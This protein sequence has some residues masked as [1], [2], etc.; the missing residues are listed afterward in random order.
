MILKGK[1]VILRPIEF[2]DL[3]FIRS[4]INNPDIERTI[5]GWALPLSRKDE[6][7]WYSSF[8]NTEKSIRYLIEDC[9]GNRVGLTGMANIDMKNGCA[10]M[11]GIRISPNVQSRGLATDAYMTIFNFAFNELRLHR[12]ETSAFD[13]NIASLKFQEKLGAKREGIRREAVYKNGDYKNVVILG[14][15]KKD[16]E[17]K[18]NN[19]IKETT[20][21]T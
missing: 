15:L 21:N 5:V 9:Q 4:L 7:K 2:D 14:C 16:F 18:Y 6:E 17:E 11:A 19:Y 13:D 10:K 20:I 12:I 8:S 3:E 1:K